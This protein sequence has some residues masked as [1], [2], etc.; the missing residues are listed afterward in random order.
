MSSTVESSTPSK[1]DVLVIGA[2]P[3]GLTCALG[4][5]KAGVNVRIVDHSPTK[6]QSGH[7]DGVMPRTIEVLQSH[8]LADALL[9]DANQVYTIS[10]Y[11]YEADCAGRVTM[12]NEPTARYPF[13]ATQNQG[14]MEGILGDALLKEGAVIERPVRPT[15]ID[16][17]T[18]ENELKDPDAYP[19]KVRVK[20][21]NEEEAA[22]E[23][24]HA[25]YVV[26]A[27]G[28]HSWVRR[29]LNV[30]MEGEQTAHVWAAIDFTPT[31]DSN[32]PDWRNIA[33]VNAK[34][35]GI[36][37]I[38]REGGKI[39][40][41]V[42]LGSEDGLVN[43][44]SGRLDS[45]QFSPDRLLEI[46]KKAFAPFVLKTTPE[47]VEWWTVYVIGQRVASTF[48]VKDRVFIAGDACHT[49]SPKGGQGMNVSINDAHNL[50]WKLAYTIR[51]WAGTSLLDT[52]EFER[53][54]FALELIAFDKW[55]AEGFS[56]KARAKLIAEGNNVDLPGPLEAFRAF[57]SVTTGIRIRYAP[58]II[59]ATAPDK[60]D[61]NGPYTLTVGKRLPPQVVLRV[62]DRRPVNV[63]D[64]CLS[65]GRFKLFV[66]TG[67]VLSADDIQSLNKLTTDLDA[68]LS[69]LPKGLLEVFSIIKAKD[70]AITYMDV[71]QTLRPHWTSIHFD[72][73][74]SGPV[75]DA[76]GIN[77]EGALVVFRPDGYV[78][79][80]TP[81]GEVELVRQYFRQFL[82]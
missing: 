74:A 16:L 80:I 23:L 38:P 24:V 46:A 37:L 61:E 3:A 52:Y 22:E 82:K 35:V 44:E 1:V 31:P 63:Q 13:A 68:L 79:T 70:D 73:H 26:G 51:G 32:F 4:L 41:Y 77:R 65:N 14:V 10:N 25:K 50:A 33:T 54:S 62:A 71:P 55:F 43:A 53:R 67:D 15:A 28:A 66:F 69:E 42:E 12:I 17:S 64:L 45:A 36:M 21:L 58:S 2:G 8:G 6:V 5:A 60:T 49:H 78:G 27:D 40:L 30:P 81:L 48:S 20:K 47:N 56:A 72:G 34:D 57:S 7:A 59:T 76:Y 9:K 18:D 39:R 19:I 29:A 75:Y 11:N